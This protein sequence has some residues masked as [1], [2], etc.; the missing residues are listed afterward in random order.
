MPRRATLLAFVVV[1]GALGVILASALSGRLVGGQGSPLVQ[2][3]ADALTQTLA[4]WVAQERDFAD[5]STLAAVTFRTGA[6]GEGQSVAGWEH[7]VELDD[8]DLLE[9]PGALPFVAGPSNGVALVGSFDGVDTVLIAVRSGL[10]EAEQAVRGVVHSAVVAPDGRTFFA[11][12]LETGTT[13]EH[14]IVRG[15]IGEDNVRLLIPGRAEPSTGDTVAS[16]L[17]LTPDAS[18]LV[19]Y[20]CRGESCVMRSYI[21]STGEAIAEARA[22]SADVF[23]VTNDTLMLSGYWTNEPSTASAIAAEVKLEQC[24]DPDAGCAT[25][26]FSLRDG[27]AAPGVVTCGDGLVTRATTTMVLVAG[28]PSPTCSRGDLQVAVVDERGT[29]LSRFAADHDLGLV[30]SSYATGLELSPGWALMARA[31][32]SS[33]QEGVTLVR[34]SDG[35]RVPATP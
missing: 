31:G 1:V 14:G 7:T 6:I 29:E 30:V 16:R 13:R 3:S 5:E 10:Q 8:I 15:T 34:L 2:G 26:L 21:A 35:L 9:I 28:V 27:T 24:N 4:R 25:G 12:V 18:K 23:G 11:L 32:Q 22:P 20:D 19:S 17:F 33:V